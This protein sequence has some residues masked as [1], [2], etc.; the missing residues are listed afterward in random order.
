MYYYKPI[1][2]AHLCDFRDRLNIV[3][4]KDL[5][6]FICHFNALLKLPK[7]MATYVSSAVA[8]EACQDMPN[9]L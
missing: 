9:I 5:Y 4:K 8:I 6:K 3:G 7:L 2:F 1:F